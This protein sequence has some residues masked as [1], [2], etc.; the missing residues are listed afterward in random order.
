MDELSVKNLVE[1]HFGGCEVIV[2]GEGSRYDITV[3][4]D[5]FVDLRPVK[6]QQLVYAALNDQIADGSIHA[7]NIA[8]YTPDEWQAR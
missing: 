5:V 8:T 3:I 4:G 6:I 2:Q 1:A 7:V